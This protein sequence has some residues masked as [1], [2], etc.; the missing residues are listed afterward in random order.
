MLKN[1]HWRAV[2]DSEELNLVTENGWKFWVNNLSIT[3]EGPGLFSRE[4][5]MVTWTVI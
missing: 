4:S 1:D 5:L 2:R 3:A